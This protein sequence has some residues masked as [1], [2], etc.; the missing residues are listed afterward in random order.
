MAHYPQEEKKKKNH[1]NINPQLIKNT[2]QK[3]MFFKK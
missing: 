3:G 2:F 1:Q